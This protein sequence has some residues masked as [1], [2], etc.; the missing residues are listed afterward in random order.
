MEW[1]LATEEEIAS[2]LRKQGVAKIRRIS[3]RKG[4]ERIQTNTYM[5]IFNHPHTPKV[6]KIG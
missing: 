3:I 1:A 6:V 5:M 4:E 2:A